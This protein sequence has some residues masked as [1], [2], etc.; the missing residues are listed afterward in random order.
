MNGT[1][2]TNV[3]NQASTTMPDIKQMVVKY[4]CQ[5]VNESNNLDII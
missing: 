5:T 1:V 3:C 2:S 4:P